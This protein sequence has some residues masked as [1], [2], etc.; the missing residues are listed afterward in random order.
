MLTPITRKKFE[1]LIPLTATADQYR[2]YWGG[3][4]DILR[5]VLISVTGVV[6]VLILRFT[7]GAGFDI[8]L[9]FLGSGTGLYWLWNPIY[10]ATRRNLECRQYKYSGFLRA[11]VLDIYT[12]EELIGKE[13]TTNKQGELVV[14]E[15]RERRINLEVGDDTGF[16]ATVQAPLLRSHR[17]IRRGDKA[18]LLVMSNR[19]DLSRIA[20][21]S[22]VYLPEAE[23]WISDY[24]YLRRDSF[25][26]VSQRLDR[27]QK[28]WG[29]P[30]LDDSDREEPPSSRRRR[31]R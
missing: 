13:E 8:I 5:R 15:N 1:E 17:S 4:S 21:L 25:I 19:G 2:Y 7:L 24:P 11:E 29:D 27:S 14:I 9:A 22:D 16:V 31:R 28:R 3:F 12:T 6:A 30:N 23:L 20:F 10:R 26:E 18:E